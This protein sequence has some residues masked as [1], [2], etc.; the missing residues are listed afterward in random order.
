MDN[1]SKPSRCPVCEGSKFELAPSSIAVEDKINNS[2]NLVRCSACQTVV[3]AVDSY[4]LSSIMLKIA[5]H[6][7]MDMA[8]FKSETTGGK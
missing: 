4:G 7:G 6:L 1:S 5:H 3:G 2:Y 8:T